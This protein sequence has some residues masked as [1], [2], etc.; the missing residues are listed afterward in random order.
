M[1]LPNEHGAWAFVLEPALL[2]LLTWPSGAGVWTALAGLLALLVQH[3]LSLLLADVRR[4][5]RYPRTRLAASFVIAYGALLAATLALAVVTA[6]RKDAFLVLVLAAPLALGQ[7]AF[8]ARNQG[9]RLAPELAGSVAIASL[10]AMVMRVAGAPWGIALVAWSILAARDL[11]SIL[12]VRARLE[13]QRGVPPGQPP[14]RVA[15]V[16]LAHAAALVWA[17]T[18]ALLAHTTWWAVP[19]FALLL[20]RAALGLRERAPA[21]PAKRVGIMEMA[22]GIVLVAALALGG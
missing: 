10:A 13:R 14:I 18:V 21:V 8:D 5:K 3:P 9:R 22:F 19:A 4:R 16:N 2:G 15:L 7:L 6:A 11:A 1:A 17:T 12:Y 20:L